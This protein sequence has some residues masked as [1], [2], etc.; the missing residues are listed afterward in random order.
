MM[1]ANSRIPKYKYNQS[2]CK[3]ATAYAAIENIRRGE[4][5]KLIDK[6]KLLANSYGYRIVSTIRLEEMDG[7]DDE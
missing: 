6:L 4:R 3:D 1:V 7:D 5:R 2:G